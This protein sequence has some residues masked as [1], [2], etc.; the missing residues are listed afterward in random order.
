[1]LTLTL[2]LV[3]DWCFMLGFGFWVLCTVCCTICAVG[4]CAMC[5][6]SS[7]VRCL[8][9]AVC[10]LLGVFC[11]AGCCMLSAGRC[12]LC[13]VCC[14]LSIRWWLD[15]VCCLPLQC[16]VSWVLG[17]VCRVLCTGCCVPYT[18]LYAGHCELYSMLDAGCLVLCAG[19]R[20][21]RTV[22]CMVGA[23]CWCPAWQ[24]TTNLAAAVMHE[25]FVGKN[26]LLV[27]TDLT[28]GK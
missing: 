17:A 25:L 23:S 9:Y 27:F 16:A 28:A 19:R 3:I 20:V 18:I 24:M 22:W 6:V 21:P 15:A 1:M 26:T 5:C 12:M 7:A 8:L 2:I 14:V 10:W 4:L 11:V 13:A